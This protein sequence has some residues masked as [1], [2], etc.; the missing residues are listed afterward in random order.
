[1]T[2]VTASAGAEALALSAGVRDALLFR[3]LSAT[4][5][6]HLGGIGRG[7]GWAGL[8]DVDAAV[9][10]LVAHVPTA[11]GG[12]FTF[13][14]AQPER[15]LGP[16][17]ARA[18]AFVRVSHDVV[19]VLG[20]PTELLHPTVAET[21][22]RHLAETLDA[23]LDDIAP[24]KRLGDE[25]EV[26]HAIRAVTTQGATDLMGT[27]RHVLE[28]AVESLSCEVGVLRVGSGHSVSTTSW[29]AFDPYDQ[30]LG[31]SLEILLKR[32][33]E[34]PLCLQE[35]DAETDLGPLGRDHGIRSLLA[36]PLP[37][38]VGGLLV[39]AHTDATP[40]GF[41]TLCQALGAQLADAASVVTH[42][43]AL[44]EELRAALDVQAIT[45][46]RDAL[47]GLGNRLAWDEAL[48]AA[49]D[50]VDSG[51]SVTV[52]TLDVDGLKHV[53]DT[54]GHEA[55][56]RLLCRCAEVLRANNGG[57][58]TITVR[59]GG[60]EFALLLPR[61]DSRAEALRA[62][63]DCAPSCEESVSASVGT[64]TALPGT[65]VADAVREADADMYASKRA[66][67]AAAAT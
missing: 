47:T 49:Q 12:V 52:I 17:Y 1:M 65:S 28:V 20:H 3:R 6:V 59:L 30:A 54:F 27:L 44:R 24:S 38:P 62:A 13:A 32:A 23:D 67:R 19:V 8:V 7:R 37:A 31:R 26:L 50:D 61:D 18:G 55:G 10:P 11:V 9:D 36:V 25:L 42:T 39:V 16:Y 22:L 15:V 43:A 35:T 4:R 51:R 57:M 14:T 53:N 33:D 5:W 2:G 66:R 46:R 56:D 48:A 64:A 60:D 40:R 63:L 58:E 41:T 21:D 29:S 45:A 34:G